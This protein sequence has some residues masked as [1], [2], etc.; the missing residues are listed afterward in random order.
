VSAYYYLKIVRAMLLEEP[1]GSSATP[2]SA[3]VAIYLTLLAAALFAAGI[4]WDPL[5]RAAQHAA[6]R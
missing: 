1:E 6:I 5:M 2:T 3:G 4:V